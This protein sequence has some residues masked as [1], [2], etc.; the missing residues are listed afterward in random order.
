M[1]DVARSFD[2]FPIHGL[3]LLAELAAN[4]NRA[5]FEAHKPE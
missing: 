2:G 4:N 3:A 5:W 1:G